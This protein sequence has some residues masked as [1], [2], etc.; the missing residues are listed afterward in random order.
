MSLFKKKKQA[1]R[2]ESII[3]SE[4]PEVMD[5]EGY[6]RLKDNILYLN[7]DGKTKVI[8]VESAMPHE[9]KTTVI[10]NLGVSLGLTDKKVIIVDLD[11]RRPR[12]QQKFGISI[13]EGIAEYMLGNIDKDKL[14]K[15]T[16]FKNVDVITRGGEIYN[17]SLVL[18]SD[19]LKNLIAS[20]KEEYDFVLLDCAPVLQV[21]DYIHVSQ[22]SDG[23]LF[24]VAHGQTTRG[25][26]KDAIKELK[27]NG[28]NI[29]G[30][31]F[32]MYDSKKDKAYGGGYYSY[33][34]NYVKDQQ[35]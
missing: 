8:Q 35:E 14:I 30:S 4:N 31:V 15:H 33:Y 32:S 17:S 11:F 9:G 25:Q 28:A 10:C 16:Q 2:E 21:S 6:S 34:S 26:V 12:V 3:V 27:K 13:D 18:V 19:K 22:M 29:L 7:A 1:I 23:I 20:L 24:L 5:S